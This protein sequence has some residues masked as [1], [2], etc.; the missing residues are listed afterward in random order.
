VPAPWSSVEK[1]YEWQ[2]ARFM[3]MSKGF[4]S[5]AGLIVTPLLAAIL[6]HV[7]T[8]DRLTG[9]RFGVAAAAAAGVGLLLH[10]AAADV[11]DEFRD[12]ANANQAQQP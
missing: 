11:A 2:Q 9:V 4:F 12:V 8:V 7:D 1:Y 5:L 10:W 6:S 3:A